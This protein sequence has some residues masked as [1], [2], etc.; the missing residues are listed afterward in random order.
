MQEQ[1]SP[2]CIGI[3]LDGNRRWASAH[4]VPALQGH[5]EGL[6]NL[7]RTVRWVREAGVQHLVVYA[8][9]TENWSRSQEEVSH[10][11]GLILQAAKEQMHRLI[12]EK[13]R[14]RFIGQ[15]DRL[16]PEVRAAIEQMEEESMRGDFT[17]WVC[18]SYGGRAEIVEAARAMQKSGEEITEESLR[19]NFW[20]TEMPDPDI[21]IRT[22]SAERLSNFLLWQ[23]AYAELFFTDTLWP[24]FSEA[25][26]GRIL[27]EYA[28][29]ERRHGK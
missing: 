6:N 19:H 11:M 8:F 22:G 10:L 27:Q 21:I 28:T 4:N 13:V 15:R 18:L 5:T 2:T 12:E 24:D 25:E 14:V 3:I 7:E 1:K 20:S 9:S 23:A 26:L 17:L 29:R 16:S